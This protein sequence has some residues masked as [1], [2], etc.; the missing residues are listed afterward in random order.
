M[1]CGTERLDSQRD[2]SLVAMD[3]CQLGRLGDEL[4]EMAVLRWEL[5][6]LEVRVAAGQVKR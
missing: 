2:T 1:S 3:R 4:K 5:A 6:S